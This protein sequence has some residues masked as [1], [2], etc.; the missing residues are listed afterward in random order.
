MK[1]ETDFKAIKELADLLLEIF[2]IKDRAKDFFCI[3]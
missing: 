1:I 2:P 3:E